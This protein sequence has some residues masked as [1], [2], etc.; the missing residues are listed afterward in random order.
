MWEIKNGGPAK[1]GSSPYQARAFKLLKN[2]DFFRSF[3][4]NECSVDNVEL[5]R[6]EIKPVELTSKQFTVQL[7]PVISV[8]KCEY[9]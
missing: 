1:F 2:F 4:M 8:V 6:F 9:F 7:W 3:L 5:F